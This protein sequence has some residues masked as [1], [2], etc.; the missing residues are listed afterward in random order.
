MAFQITDFR[1]S[2]ANIEC[3]YLQLSSYIDELGIPSIRQTYAVDACNLAA[4]LNDIASRVALEP[5]FLRLR[6]LLLHLH[7]SH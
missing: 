1:I 7:A 3:G 2:V 6:W 5:L 4:V